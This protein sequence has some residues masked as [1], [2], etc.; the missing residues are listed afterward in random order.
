MFDE[1]VEFVQINIGKQLGGQITER[2]AELETIDHLSKQG[3]KTGVMDPPGQQARK[4]TAIDR[5]KVFSDV[6]LQHPNRHGVVSAQPP[7]QFLKAIHSAVRAF[8]LAA[9]P[10]VKNKTAL[11]DRIDDADDGVV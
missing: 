2:D 4:D 1:M 9:R 7:G 11:K 3:D 10:R 6:E 5:S 8:A